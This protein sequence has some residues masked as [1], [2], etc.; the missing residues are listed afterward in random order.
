M[1]KRVLPIAPY[2]MRGSG[3]GTSADELVSY[4]RAMEAGSWRSPAMPMPIG[5]ATAGTSP[6]AVEW[7][8]RW[9]T[10]GPLGRPGAWETLPPPPIHRLKGGT[11]RPCS[12]FL[13]KGG[14]RPNPHATLRARSDR[15]PGC[16]TCYSVAAP[17]NFLDYES[18]LLDSPA[19][20]GRRAQSRR[21]K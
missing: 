14:G 19:G 1:R 8:T 15:I 13:Q 4:L 7:A 20:H 5:S 9:A 10:E 17:H 21:E 6:L 2:Y 3:R 18:V 11:P 16:R 12:F